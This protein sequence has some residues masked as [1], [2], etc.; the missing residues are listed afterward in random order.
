M[1]KLIII[2]ILSYFIGLNDKVEAA[3]ESVKID[4][5][6]V[7]FSSNAKVTP[8]DFGRILDLKD[9]F[10]QTID[11]GLNKIGGNSWINVGAQSLSAPATI[12]STKNFRFDLQQS[13]REGVDS[14]QIQIN[15]QSKLD[16][17]GKPSTVCGFVFKKPTLM[18]KQV[19]LFRINDVKAA[20]YRACK[21]QNKQIAIIEKP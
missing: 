2:L 13:T 14:Y 11:L 9:D 21:E 5:L 1:K 8:L 15:K 3:T 17:P 7:S 16:L 6:K 4:K 10:Y 20:F 12:V 18:S 19:Y